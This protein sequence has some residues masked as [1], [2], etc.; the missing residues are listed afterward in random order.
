MKRTLT[1]QRQLLKPGAPPTF[2]PVKNRRPRT[3]EV[4]AETVAL[5]KAH[6]FHQAEVKLANRTP[7]HDNGL[8][9]AKDWDDCTR[10]NDVL[11]DPLQSNNLGQRIFAKLIKAAGVRRIKLHGLRHT[12]AALL[13]QAGVA[14]HVVQRRLGHKRIEM[15]LG[16]YGHVLPAMQQDAAARLAALLHG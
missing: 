13:L 9:F 10:Q 1:I 4:S 7:Y 16:I 6:R 11:G 3:I 15:T 8:V 12:S 2:G 14:P 5:L